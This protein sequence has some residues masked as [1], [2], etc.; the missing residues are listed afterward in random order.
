[1]HLSSKHGLN[2]E[3]ASRAQ[4]QQKQ[5]AQQQKREPRARG[6]ALKKGLV[7][8]ICTLMISG[9]SG[10]C[11]VSKKQIT[12]QTFAWIVFLRQKHFYHF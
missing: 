12:T 8:Y 7:M 1:M 5:Q 11:R 3:R 6:L 10:A 2:F 9:V 4:S